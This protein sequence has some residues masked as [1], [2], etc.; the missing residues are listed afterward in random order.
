MY[1]SITVEYAPTAAQTTPQTPHDL[2]KKTLKKKCHH[3]R[4][5]AQ[6]LSGKLGVQSDL[7]DLGSIRLMGEA[8]I[9]IFGCIHI[10]DNDSVATIKAQTTGLSPLTPRISAESRRNNDAFVSRA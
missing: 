5:L 3:F 6:A 10:S 7:I 8:A 2:C 1:F 4:S 9:E